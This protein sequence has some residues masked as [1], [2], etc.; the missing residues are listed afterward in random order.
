MLQRHRRG[1]YSAHHTL[2]P[3]ERE[4]GQETQC[5]QCPHRLEAQQLPKDTGSLP[6]LTPRAGTAAAGHSQGAE[7]T[8]TEKLQPLFPTRPVY[9][10][11]APS[12]E[13]PH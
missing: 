8:L 2:L 11:S 10:F 13:A 9:L 3:V 1:R 5:A 6:S 7:G 12:P 4:T